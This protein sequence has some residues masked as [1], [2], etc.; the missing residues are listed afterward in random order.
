MTVRTFCDSAL[1]HELCAV[2]IRMAGFAVLRRPL[3][4]NIMS[5]RLRLVTID[6]SNHAVTP[7][8]RKFCFRMVEAPDVDPGPRAVA[9]FAPQRSAV[10]ALL[11]HAILEF[12]LMRIGVAGGARL[13]L[14]MERKNLVCSSGKAG[15][16]ALRASHGH[17]GAGQREVCLLVLGNRERRTM[18]VF[19]SVTIL[20]TILV[21]SGGKL[22][23]V[24]VLVA[25]QAGREFYFVDG[26]LAGG[27]VAL[28]ALHGRMFSFKRIFRSGMLLHAKLR[29]LPAVDGVALRALSLACPRLEL[30]FVRIWGMAARTLGKG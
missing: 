13:I 4:L 29:R 8:Q 14:E 26:V 7:N 23:V 3:E 17:V 11:R 28:F 19:Y 2:R 22:L 30:P 16:V 10:S 9:R 15:L 12:A 21:G 18:K 24:R 5:A 6:T 25:I 1:I 20:T 27:R